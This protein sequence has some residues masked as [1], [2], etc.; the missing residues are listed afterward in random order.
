MTEA[1]SNLF[2]DLLSKITTERFLRLAPRRVDKA[3]IAIRQSSSAIHC[4]PR[5][6]F[7][8]PLLPRHRHVSSR[9]S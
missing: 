6:V 3:L 7:A 5:R 9:S 4:R 8:W 2:T 1:A